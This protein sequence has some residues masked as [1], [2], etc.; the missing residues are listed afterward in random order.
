MAPDVGRK[1]LFPVVPFTLPQ[2]PPPD[3]VEVVYATIAVGGVD[4][5]GTGAAGLAVAV[6]GDHSRIGRRLRGFLSEIQLM[7]QLVVRRNILD[8]ERRC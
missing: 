2:A 5:A 4:D 7:H 3:L 8:W 1:V 6:E